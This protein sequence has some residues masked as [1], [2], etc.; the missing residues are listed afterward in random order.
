M[1]LG[2]ELAVSS[3]APASNAAYVNLWAAGSRPLYVREVFISQTTTTPLPSLTLVRTS[4]RGTQTTTVTPTAAAN[5]QNTNF[6][7]PT[8]VIDTA[9]S[10]Q[11]TFAANPM[12][13]LDVAGVVGSFS[14]WTW[15]Q[16]GEIFVPSGAGLALENTSGGTTGV[17][18][19]YFVWGE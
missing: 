8:A 16:D 3:L 11:P 19:A 13:E 1:I 15:S 10:V 17:V 6:A 4:A 14:L 12:R 9:W 5:D 7:A 2:A 18:R